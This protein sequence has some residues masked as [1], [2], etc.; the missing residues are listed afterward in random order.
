MRLKIPIS[1]LILCSSP[2]AF[3][4]IVLLSIL[5][6]AKDINFETVWEAFFHFDPENVNH[7]IVIHSRLPRAIGA[8]LIG[9]FLA[10][11]GSIMQGMTRN[12]LASPSILGVSDGS[13]FAITLCMIFMPDASSF[14]H[15]NIFTT[16]FSHCCWLRL[17]RGVAYAKR[18]VTRSNGDH[19]NYYW[20]VSQQY[21]RCLVNVFSSIA[22]HQFL[23]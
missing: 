4:L 22:K 17:R 19:R 7:Q 5:Y 23:V 11:S 15:D 16:R 10:I 12:Y 18:N 2:I 1:I 20:N 3:V 6:G 13:V 8:L 14:E 9:I 21:F